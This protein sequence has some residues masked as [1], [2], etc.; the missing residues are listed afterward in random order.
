MKKLLWICAASWLVANAEV[1]AQNELQREHHMESI[2]RGIERISAGVDNYP[3]HRDCFSCHHQAVPLLAYRLSA[4]EGSQG[5]ILWG[6]QAQ[7][8]DRILDFTRRSL[9]RELASLKPEQELGGR[10]MTLGYALWTLSVGQTTWGTLGEELVSKAIS[11]QMH[12]GRWRVH[13]VRPPAASSEMM[14]TAL[15]ISGLNHYERYQKDAFQAVSLNTLQKARYRA[16]LWRAR[17]AEPTT[18]EDL[19]GTIWFDYE[20]RSL[21]NESPFRPGERPPY[22]TFQ[23]PRFLRDKRLPENSWKITYPMIRIPEEPFFTGSQIQELNRIFDFDQG[24]KRRET[25]IKMQ[26]QDG[27]WGYQA[28]RES[29]AY[30]TATALLILAQT[31]SGYSKSGLVHEEPLLSKGLQYLIDTQHKDGSWHVSSRANP[32]Q[33]FFDNGDPHETD[34]FISM[35]A[36]AW[37][38]AA[39]ASA[40]HSHHLPLSTHASYDPLDWIEPAP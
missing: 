7:R 26:N 21:M 29:E 11:T 39:L 28:G 35:Q 18:T 4:A 20:A 36:T 12:D 24:G 13:S 16:M 40:Y 1:Y 33:E 9:E 22:W 37:A 10:G 34:Q 25:L 30:S 17:Q 8:R 14:A 15:V 19:C 3:K 31:K 23:E 5:K 2:E 32:V 27:G 38:V 6:D